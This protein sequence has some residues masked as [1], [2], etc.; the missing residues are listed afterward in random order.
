MDLFVCFQLIQTTGVF[1]KLLAFI[2]GSTNPE[3]QQFTLLVIAAAS[4]TEE[5]RR[6]FY[7]QETEKTLITLLGSDVNY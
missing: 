4:K 3:I 1:D 2:A 6:I 5:N 7:E